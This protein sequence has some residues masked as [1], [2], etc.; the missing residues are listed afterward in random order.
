MQTEPVNEVTEPINEDESQTFTRNE[1]THDNHSVE[2]SRER[3]KEKRSRDRSN[4]NSRRYHR[5][6]SNRKKDEKTHSDHEKV[7]KLDKLYQ[8]THQQ[9]MIFQSQ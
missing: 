8:K 9:M 5:S 3:E 7:A 4:D 2:R 1:M 6:K